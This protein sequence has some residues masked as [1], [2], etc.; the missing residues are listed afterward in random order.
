MNKRK[1]KRKI[2]LRVEDKMYHM[3]ICPNTRD[4][5]LNMIFSKKDRFHWKTHCSTDCSH[6]DCS[7]YKEMHKVK[8]EQNGS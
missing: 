6:I 5:I 7:V 2:A 4:T 3:G 1:L 8:E